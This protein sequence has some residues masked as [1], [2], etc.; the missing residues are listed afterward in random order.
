VPVPISKEEVLAVT[1]YGAVP[2]AIA[3]AMPT[4]QLAGCGSAVAKV[5]TMSP[6]PPLGV[7]VT[8]PEDAEQWAPLAHVTVPF[9]V[10]ESENVTPFDPVIMGA[11]TDL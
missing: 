11:V 2:T 8:I 3:F 6:L 9:K 1:V 10:P 7:M 5:T 4:T